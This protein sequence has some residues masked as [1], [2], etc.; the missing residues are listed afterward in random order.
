MSDTYDEKDSYRG[1]AFHRVDL[2]GATF[3]D[4]DLANV[5]I[6][7]SR[8]DNL[9]ISGFDGRA[10]TVVIDDVDVTAY[11]E[12]ELD[13]R[14]PE[15]VRLRAL[16]SAD[17]YRAMWQLLDQLWTTTLE[18]ARRL[19]EQ[20]TTERVDGEWSLVE[21][22]RHLVFA[23]DTWVGRFIRQD[24]RP[25]HRFGLPPTDFPA[26]EA[27]SLGLDLTASPSFE[28]AVAVHAE[29]RTGVQA[30]L[31]D[32]ADAQL[33]DMRTAV[34]PVWGEESQPISEC[35]AVV[36]NEHCEHR[37]FAVRDLAVLAHG[38]GS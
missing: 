10:G 2:T 31:V 28:E 33:H 15:R 19:P 24:E 29:R 12:S 37:R 27:S 23:I 5:R 8:V 21:T 18:D 36:F 13:R 6:A 1:A 34:L 30:V 38:V 11:V 14:H 32:L 25:F 17:D 9:N 3:R 7:S 26:T 4:C 20:L 16:E 22:L 35:L